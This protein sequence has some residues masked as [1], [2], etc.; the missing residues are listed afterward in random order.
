MQETAENLVDQAHFKYIHKKF[1]D[2]FT[3]L[4]Y[5]YNMKNIYADD[6]NLYTFMEHKNKRINAKI[7]Y[8]LKK[9]INEKNKKYVNVVSI[10]IYLSF[11]GCR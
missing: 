1:F 3:F 6:K 9:H 2:M 5:H 8:L 4:T 11:F 7:Q 10:D